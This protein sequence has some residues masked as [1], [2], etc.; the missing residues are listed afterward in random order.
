MWPPSRT[1]ASACAH[2]QRLRRPVV[3]SAQC[4]ARGATGAA[5][6]LCTGVSSVLDVLDHLPVALRPRG[7]AARRCRARR[8]AGRGCP[9]RARCGAPVAP[10]A[11]RCAPGLSACRSSL[12]RISSSGSRQA[13]ISDCCR[14]ASSTFSRQLHRAGAQ[15]RVGALRARGCAA[16]AP[17]RGTTAASPRNRAAARPRESPRRRGPC[18]APQSR[19]RSWRRGGRAGSRPAGRQRLGHVGEVLLDRRLRPEGAEERG[20]AHHHQRGDHRLGV[21]HDPAAAGAWPRRP[22]P[23]ASSAGRCSDHLADAVG[24][25]RRPR[26]PQRLQRLGGTCQHRESRP[27]GSAPVQAARS[28][29]GG[30]RSELVGHG[31]PRLE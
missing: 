1:V 8:R 7:S 20:D 15:R 14:S 31:D 21:G 9:S 4:R 2:R 28:R 23:S 13:R 26:S 3:Q 25:D 10:P 30:Q 6:A 29:K 18:G 11:A 22:A 24:V 19:E 12:M 5:A 27:R 16:P 17:A